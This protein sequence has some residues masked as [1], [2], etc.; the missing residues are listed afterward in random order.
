[1]EPLVY[2]PS[3]QGEPVAVSPSQQEWSPPVLVVRPPVANGHTAELAAMDA[4]IG[5]LQRAIMA[6]STAVAEHEAASAAQTARIEK[7]AAARDASTAAQ[8]ARLEQTVALLAARLLAVEVAAPDAHT[9]ADPD[10]L[11]RHDPGASAVP[12]PVVHEHLRRHLDPMIS[13]AECLEAL[14]D[15]GFRVTKK[16]CGQRRADPE[17]WSVKKIRLTSAVL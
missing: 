15:R 10:A 12:L 13:V 11:L 9:N 7:A 2:P 14:A 1:M 8:I 4:G 6:T 3:P 16:M 17:Y 5:Q